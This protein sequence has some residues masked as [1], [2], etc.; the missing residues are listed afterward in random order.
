MLPLDFLMEPH[1]FACMLPGY[2]IAL[3]SRGEPVI[4][5]YPGTIF[6]SFF[7]VTSSFF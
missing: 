7:T 4:M 3:Y 1:C 5:R 2:S 6:I